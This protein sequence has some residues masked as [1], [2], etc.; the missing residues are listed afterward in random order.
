MNYNCTTKLA[1]LKKTFNY[2]SGNSQN[3]IIFVHFQE[4]THAQ[5]VREH[6]KNYKK[7]DIRLEGFEK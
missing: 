5:N 4:N 6:N 7:T 2:S 1:A 3:N